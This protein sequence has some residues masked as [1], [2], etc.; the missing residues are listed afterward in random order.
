M[1]KFIYSIISFSIVILFILAAVFI[2]VRRDDI[3]N[4]YMAGIV[5]KHHRLNHTKAPRLIF[6]GGSNLAF[7]L[8]SE[9]IE[10][11]FSVPVVNLALHGG[12]GLKFI[13]S[14]LRS[15][16]KSGDVVLLSPEYF[17]DVDGDL[18]IKRNTAMYFKEADKYFQFNLINEFDEHLAKARDDA[19][20]F[21]W[22]RQELP[23]RMLDTIY[24][25]D[26]F[27]KYGDVISHLERPSP[28]VYKDQLYLYEYSKWAGIEELNK[29][30]IFA[31][32][33]SVQVFFIYPPF[34]KTMFDRNELVLEHF[35]ADISHRLAI[36]I[37][38]KPV[39][40]VFPDSLFF[41][42]MYHLNK[43]GR[44]IRTAELIR[45][46]KQNQ[47]ALKALFSIRRP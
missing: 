20:A 21:Q 33:I 6:A 42:T 47:P 8:N 19:K 4:D 12:L 45:I 18:K 23:T 9:Q 41:D 16:I 37:L 27:N 40:F 2:V 26:A 15:N 35:S 14:E 28:K 1:K 43:K 7:G 22:K 25:K 44:E 39:D 32:L 31:K 3:G 46:I 10:K 36:P 24:N 11:E 38:N 29:F 30:Q 17:L 5:A 13:L 34:P